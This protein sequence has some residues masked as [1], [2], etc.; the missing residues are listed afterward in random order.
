VVSAD[1][2]MRRRLEQ[3]RK[4]IVAILS[5]ITTN[6]RGEGGRIERGKGSY[7]FLHYKEDK[8]EGYVGMRERQKR[9]RERERVKK[10][11][12]VKETQIESLLEAHR[13]AHRETHKEIKI[14][15]Q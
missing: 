10:E 5:I 4:V 8:G 7:S 11:K 3:P 6:I 14:E 1:R 12:R 13:E 2:K 15:M 9:E